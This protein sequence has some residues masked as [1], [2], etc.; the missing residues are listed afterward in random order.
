MPLNL[1]PEQRLYRKLRIEDRG[2]D[3][4]C[5][6]S[7]QGINPDGYATLRVDGIG[8]LAHRLSYTLFVGE[9]PEGLILDHL[10]R[11]HNCI[12]PEHLQP[13]TIG[14][15]IRR[16]EHPNVVAWR[17]GRCLQ[18]HRLTEDNIT[19]RSDGRVRCR[20]CINEY[21]RRSRVTE[22]KL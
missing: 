5:W 13:V 3:T 10:C 15:N 11:Q 19:M 20:K 12:N 4:P 14:E 17:E 2:Y 1:S 7:Y 16:G 21:A 22:S 8:W 9:I 6:L 18:G